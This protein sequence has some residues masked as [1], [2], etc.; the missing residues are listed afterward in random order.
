MIS[1]HFNSNALKEFLDDK[2]ILNYNSKKIEI[3]S[4][5]YFYIIYTINYLCMLDLVGIT[6]LEDKLLDQEECV[7]DLRNDINVETIHERTREFQTHERICRMAHRACEPQKPSQAVLAKFDE[8][9]QLWE[10]VEY[11]NEET[12]LILLEYKLALVDAI[13]MAIAHAWGV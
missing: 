6:Y 10:R 11:L 12:K 5:Y 3:L 1:N 4:I 2:C 8:V 9:R 7:E 13:N